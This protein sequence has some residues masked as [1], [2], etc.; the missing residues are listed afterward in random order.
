D[1]IR[2]VAAR[3]I[4]GGMALAGLA[5]H[6]RAEDR[7][8]ALVVVAPHREMLGLRLLGARLGLGIGLGDHH[9]EPIDRRPA[10]AFLDAIW[11]MIRRG[12]RAVIE[13]G[14]LRER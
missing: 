6:R 10:P 3:G 1:D 2:H 11:G 5:R 12:E 4:S 14:L 7:A 13:A 8:E 9:G